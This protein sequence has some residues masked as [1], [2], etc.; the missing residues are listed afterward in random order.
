MA[1]YLGALDQAQPA[2]DSSC[3]IDAAVLFR[4]PRRNTNIYFRGPDGWNT[5]HKRFGAALVKSSRTPWRKKG[6]ADQI[7]Q[8]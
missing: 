8:R 1:A 5:I 7:W 3:L 4:R 6:C 2:R